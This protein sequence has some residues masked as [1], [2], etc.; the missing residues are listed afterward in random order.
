VNPPFALR[1]TRAALR[2]LPAELRERAAARL[3]LVHRDHGE[4]PREIALRAAGAATALAGMAATAFGPRD[5]PVALLLHGWEGRG[6]QLG[7]YIEPLVA[8]GHR[9]LALDAPG[10]GR[11]PG[12][13]ALPTWA[14]AF[15]AALRSSDARLVVA[16]SFGG[17]VAVVAAARTGFDGRL[18]CLGGPP[19]T[20]EMFDT[21]RA[22]LGLGR[23]G[24]DRFVAAL[25][26]RFAGRPWE[27]LMDIA[28]TAAR[29]QCR[30][31]AMNGANDDPAR[32]ASSLRVAAAARAPFVRVPGVGHR[33]VMWHA[34]AVR[35]GVGFLLGD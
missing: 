3:F 11:T 19:E 5:G 9:V 6:L 28:A 21:G 32:H 17:A 24:Q 2:V 20:Q 31:L 26:R 14:D 10:H 4:P 27:D 34:D 15:E 1:L 29:L 35:T 30:L 25:R 13:A 18:L 23:D 16:H 22:L 8:A 12:V 33:D 7:A